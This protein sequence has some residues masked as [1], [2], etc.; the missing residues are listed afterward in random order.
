MHLLAICTDTD[1]SSIATDSWKNPIQ[2]NLTALIYSLVNGLCKIATE[3]IKLVLDA[4]QSGA[5]SNLIV[6]TGDVQKV[7]FSFFFFFFFY[8]SSLRY[9]MDSTEIPSSIF[10][11]TF[12]HKV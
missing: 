9:S 1:G 2:N 6:P 11:P 4:E 7:L 5:S 3:S 8:A 12:H 10:Q